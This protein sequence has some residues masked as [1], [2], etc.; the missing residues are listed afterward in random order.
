MADDLPE[1]WV[2]NTLA[3]AALPEPDARELLE[4]VYA[5]TRDGLQG[6]EMGFALLVPGDDATLE[7]RA[8]ALG[9]WC[10]GFL[11]GMAVRGLRDMEEL[12]DELREIL[13]DLSE[14]SR[15]G[16][17][18][19]ETDEEGEEAWAELVEYVRVAVQLVFDQT[20]PPAGRD[21]VAVP[22]LH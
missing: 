1:A 7:E 10:Q 13:G 4:A 20:S 19:E 17:A 3:D 8:D 2:Q 18:R 16:V 9:A 5:A 14:I 6:T 15:A 12:P 11:Y 21:D 22:V